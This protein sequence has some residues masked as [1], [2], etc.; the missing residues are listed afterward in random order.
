MARKK[1]GLNQRHKR[2]IQ[3]L[4]RFQNEFGFPPTIR[5]IGENTEISSTSVVNYY[6]NQL[7]EM[8]YIERSS[9]VSRGIKLFKDPKRR[10]CPKI[11][12]D[13]RCYN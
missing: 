2:I 8:H 6:L 3:F 1:S 12:T 11:Q 13:S 7:E 10:G 5:E 4:E 9:N